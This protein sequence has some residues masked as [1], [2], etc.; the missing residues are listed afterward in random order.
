MPGMYN[1]PGLLFFLENKK[2]EL[3]AEGDKVGYEFKNKHLRLSECRSRIKVL[4]S[5]KQRKTPQS[6]QNAKRL[7]KD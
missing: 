7:L 6:N 5:V 2:K 4:C 1:V 3:I